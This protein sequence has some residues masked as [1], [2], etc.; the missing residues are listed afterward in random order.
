MIFLG[1][2]SPRREDL[3]K[4]L[5]KSFSLIHKDIE[6]SFDPVLDPHLVPI[7]LADKKFESIAQDIQTY[8]YLITADTV[9]IVNN[10]ILNKPEHEGEAIA[11]LQKLSGSYHEVTTGV[12]IG[13][14]DNKVKFSDTTKVY[15]DTLTL[16]EITYYIEAFKPYDKAGG[17]GIQDWIGMAKICKIEGSYTNV[18]GLPTQKLYCVLKENFPELLNVI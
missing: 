14:G 10:E 2:K 5:I 12:V 9:V 7:Y 17:Y 3:L 1:S 6:E 16:D 11:M 15:M 18:M 13:M 4:T 8:D